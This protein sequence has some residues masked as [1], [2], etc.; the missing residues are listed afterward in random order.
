MGHF[1]DRPTAPILVREVLARHGMEVVNTYSDKRRYTTF[2]K[3]VIGGGV[4]GGIV[5]DQQKIIK[6][7][8]AEMTKHGLPCNVVDFVYYDSPTLGE[9][10]GVVMTNLVGNFTLL[11][12]DKKEV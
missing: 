10:W 12:R 2:R 11:N 5:G 4:V 8:K 9:Y 3:F 7:V 1:I 6:E